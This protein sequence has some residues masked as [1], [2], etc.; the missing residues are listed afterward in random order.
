MKKIDC[1]QDCNAK[2][3]KKQDGF[4]LAYAFDRAEV[5]MFQE[6]EIQLG[7]TPFGEYIMPSDCVF[8][9]KN[10]CELHNTQSQPQCCVENKAGSELCTHIRSM[11]K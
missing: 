1:L 4:Q 5:Q 2:C 6:R 10:L 3:C 9:A 7:R 8:L 11:S